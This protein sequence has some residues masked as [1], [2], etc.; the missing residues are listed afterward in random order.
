MFSPELS[1]HWTAEQ[2][3]PTPAASMT[4]DDETLSPSQQEALEAL[5]DRVNAARSII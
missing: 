2:D 4:H 1:Q 3:A 5:V